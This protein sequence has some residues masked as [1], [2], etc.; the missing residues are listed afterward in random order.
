MMIGDELYTG[1]R[2]TMLQVDGITAGESYVNVVRAL[3]D[4]GNVSAF[5]VR[6]FRGSYQ[7]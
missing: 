2:D 6:L 5:S 4:A 7:Y 3:D 1:I